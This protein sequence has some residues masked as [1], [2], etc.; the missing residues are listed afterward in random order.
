MQRILKS[1]T[2]KNIA[3]KQKLLPFLNLNNKFRRRRR[4]KMK[5]KLISQFHL[6]KMLWMIKNHQ[7]IKIHFIHVTMCN[8]WIMYILYIQLIRITLCTLIWLL[9]CVQCSSVVSHG[10]ISNIFNELRFHKFGYKTKTKH[11]NS[12]T[13]MSRLQYLECIIIFFSFR[14]GKN[15]GSK[16]SNSVKDPI[17]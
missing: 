10:H 4:R 16:W 8:L 2:T 14:D 17:T 12:H 3:W 6:F 9:I 7:C 5:D 15:Y 11:K 13:N 1:F